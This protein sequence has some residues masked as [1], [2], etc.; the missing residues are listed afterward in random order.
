MKVVLLWLSQQV[1]WISLICIIGAIGY[2]A[3]ALSSRRRRNTAQFSLE[4]EVYQQR[5][6]RAW[7]IALLF[8]LLAAVILG[9]S[10]VWGPSTP[11][12][13]TATSHTQKWFIYI[14]SRTRRIKWDAECQQSHNT[15]CSGSTWT[16]RAHQ[17]L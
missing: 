15:G 16:Y 13:E 6:T 1:I 4:R 3:L 17:H 14:D 5:T 8:L 9:I 10:I 7:L 11:L 12:L 2:I